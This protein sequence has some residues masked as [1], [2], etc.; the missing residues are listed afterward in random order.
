MTQQ[1]DTA[2]APID[3]VITWVDGNSA[4]HQRKRAHYM[5]LQTAPLGENATNPHRWRDNDE[6]TFCLHSI[7]R[8]AP[9]VR[10][11]WIVVD[12]R[13]P[14]L[15]MLPSA[16]RR[17]TRIVQHSDIFRGFE[18]CLPT[19]NSLAIESL[20]WRIDGLSERFLYFNDDV[21]L[22]A[23]LAPRDVFQGMAPVLRGRWVDCAALIEN[24]AARDDPAKFNYFM[25]V[26]A[27]RLMGYKAQHL[28]KAAHVVHPM[29]RS[30]MAELFAQHPEAF[31]ANVAHRFRDLSQFLPQGLHNH[32]CLARGLGV[33]QSHVDH[34][35]ITSGQG[36]GRPP[37]ELRSLLARVTEQK[38]KFLCINDL[39]QFEALIPEARAALSRLTSAAAEPAAPL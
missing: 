31:A 30:V 33:P 22:T 18:D 3:C 13:G 2:A 6:I 23:P 4:E 11:V 26:N 28:F 25:Q 19:F 21:F 35:H 17:K 1:T 36:V 34:L 37:A 8:H 24:P 39:P 27:A 16:I 15:S 32:A 29:R 7:A 5:G 10:R 20:L 38:L 14:D 12:G 9:W